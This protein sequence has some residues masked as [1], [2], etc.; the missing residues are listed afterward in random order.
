M[1]NKYVQ[2]KVGTITR[3]QGDLM[4]LAFKGIHTY[5]HPFTYTYLKMEINLTKKVSTSSILII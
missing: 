2:L 4:P 1:Q 3:T 5:M